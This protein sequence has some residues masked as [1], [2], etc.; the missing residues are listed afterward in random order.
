MNVGNQIKKRGRPPKNKTDT[1]TTSNT[2]ETPITTTH[3]KQTIPI[4]SKTYSIT[5]RATNGIM[6]RIDTTI[7][8]LKLSAD[9]IEQI[10]NS[11]ENHH[12]YMLPMEIMPNG[13]IET[14]GCPLVQVQPPS[15][16]SSQPS[17]QPP[18][19]PSS[20]PSSQQSQEQL[21]VTTVVPVAPI[22]N[23]TRKDLI[24]N[25]GIVR[26]VIKL[27]IQG[28]EWPQSSPYDCWND[29][30]PFNGPPVGIPENYLNGIFYLSGNFC[31]FNCA[32]KYLCPNLDN[33]DDCAIL[34]SS[35]DHY[36]NDALS[37]K[38]QLLELMCHIETGMDIEQ[39]IKFAPPRLCLK[40]FGGYL[41]IEKYRESFITYQEY[42][43]FKTPM[44]PIV[45]QVEET[46]GNRPKNSHFVPLDLSRV[47]K[48]HAEMIKMHN[49][50][51]T[52]SKTK[53]KKANRI[54]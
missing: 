45:Y 20:Q 41:T 44:I 47:E 33:L 42:H 46:V 54:S 26:K 36:T 3:V 38:I 13:I 1:K 9:E 27:S 32:M 22:N 4:V 31:S 37:E 50:E 52:K 43:V 10:E 35:L 53:S 6:K 29:C 30:H 2:A 5:T 25:S 51:K 28:D 15:Q 40:K 7:L 16:P 19:Q 14:T 24:I 12:L 34:N 23:P 48:A 39:R 11:F 17:S 18:S 21:P 8:H 49:N